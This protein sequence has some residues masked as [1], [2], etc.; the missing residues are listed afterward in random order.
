MTKFELIDLMQ[1]IEAEHEGFYSEAKA[2]LWFDHLKNRSTAEVKRAIFLAQET[3][4][5][6]PRIADIKKHLPV[7]KTDYHR[8][9]REWRQ[10]YEQR[11]AEQG[12]V[13]VYVD[14][15]NG[16]KGS[17]WTRPSTAIGGNNG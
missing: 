9:P 10:Q 13:K 6:A 7:R 11:M 8:A 12:L 3:S 4:H 1:T 16:R 17:T 15:G 2:D 5:F 14:L